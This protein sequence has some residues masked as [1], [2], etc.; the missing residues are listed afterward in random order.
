MATPSVSRIKALRA[1]DGAL[2]I[3]IIGEVY[4]WFADELIRLLMAYKPTEVRFIMRS[5]GGLAFDVLDVVDYMNANGIKSYSEIYGECSS[6]ATFLAAHSTPERT[7][8]TKSS[9]FGIHRASGAIGDDVFVAHANERIVD[10]YVE[11]FGWTKAKAEK[12]LDANNGTGTAW[13]GEE[14]IA[15][16]IAT[17]LLDELKVAARMDRVIDIINTNTMLKVKAKLVGTID[18]VKALVTGQEVEVSIDPATI[19]A[20]S[21]DALKTAQ[22]ELAKAITDRQAAE[23]K[24]KEAADKVSALEADVKAANEAKTSAETK[25]TEATAKVTEVTAKLETADKRVKALETALD[26]ALDRPA[27]SPPIQVN[28]EGIVSPLRGPGQQDD[29]PA[30]QAARALA[31]SMTASEKAQ[32]RANAEK[33]NKNK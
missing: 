23:A 11:A 8:V 27:G 32:A 6:A 12:Y 31:A 28:D 4:G 5:P 10:L 20:A 14:I 3:P 24:E 1:P 26:K 17:E 21:N 29:S 19:T 13:M 2:D 18:T 25:A 33:R 9:R 16:G 30:G 15:A 7:A 22:D